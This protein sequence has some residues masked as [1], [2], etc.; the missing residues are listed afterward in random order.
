M[1]DLEV[2]PFVETPKYLGVQ[3][4]LL[5]ARTMGQKRR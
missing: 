3:S 4:G 5:V 2:P 1:D